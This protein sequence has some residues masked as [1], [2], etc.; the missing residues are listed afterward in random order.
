[1]TYSYRPKGVC[2]SQITFEIDEQGC[3]HNLQFRGGCNGNTQGLSRLVEGMNADEVC[4]RLRGV[5]C[6]MRPS[7]CP[8]QLSQAIEQ[9]LQG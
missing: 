5:R 1:M 9:A 3:V 6:G 2:S 8:D 7:S 4:R